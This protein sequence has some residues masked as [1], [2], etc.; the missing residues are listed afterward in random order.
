MKNAFYVWKFLY[1]QIL[2]PPAR[3][4]FAGPIARSMTQYG[5]RLIQQQVGGCSI[6]EEA[7][8]GLAQFCAKTCP[9]IEPLTNILI[10]MKG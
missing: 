8:R 6:Q 1:T 9:I 4:V 2:K 7:E 10:N 3:D 5:G